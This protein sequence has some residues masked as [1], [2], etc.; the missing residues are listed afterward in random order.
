MIKLPYSLFAEDSFV[1]SFSAVFAQSFGPKEDLAMCAV[2]VEIHRA[3]KK[4]KELIDKALR[5]HGRLDTKTAHYTILGC[6]EAQVAAF[7]AYKEKLDS[8]TF[9]VPLEAPLK[10]RKTET[11]KLAPVAAALLADLVTVEWNG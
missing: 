7:L 6:D 4:Y 1:N 8:E 5:T 9:E 10:I 3:G 2:A 11:H